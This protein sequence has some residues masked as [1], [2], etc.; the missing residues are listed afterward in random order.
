VSPVK[1]HARAKTN[2]RYRK[3]VPQVDEGVRAGFD[4]SQ[5]QSCLGQRWLDVPAMRRG[6]A[7]A[8]VA[9]GAVASVASTAAWATHSK[10]A[11]NYAA[12]LGGG[13]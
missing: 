4:S 9:L 6:T 2:V 12:G 5:R 10:F 3:L 13:W 1:E 7:A 11:F 8:S